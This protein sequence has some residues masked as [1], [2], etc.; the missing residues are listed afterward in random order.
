MEELAL[1]SDNDFMT[2]VR[3]PGTHRVTH[4]PRFQSFSYARP[5]LKPGRTRAVVRLS[6]TDVLA[7]LVQVFAP[8]GGER[9]MHSHAAADGFWLVL[10]GTARFYDGDGA[11]RDYG[12]L[13]GVTIPR[14]VR[15]WFEAVS[16]EPLE[17]VQV[18]AV[19]KGVPNTMEFADPRSYDEIKE[20]SI[21]SVSFYDGGISS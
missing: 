7:G 1:D 6:T 11:F 13:E 8:G 16:D 12:R 21:G 19:M 15:Y 5:E 10:S 20:D 17:M 4:E 14:G 9:H 2:M 3:N 18:E